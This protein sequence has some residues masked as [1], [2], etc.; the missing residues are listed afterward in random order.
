MGRPDSRKWIVFLPG[1]AID[2]VSADDKDLLALLPKG[3]RT[4][5]FLVINKARDAITRQRRLED[6]LSVLK[7]MIP[8]H[9]DI[10]LIGYSEGAYI[11][12]SIAL[13]CRRVRGLVLLA[14]GTRGWIEDELNRMSPGEAV[15]TIPEILKILSRKTPD[16]L[17][18][19]H[20][21]DTWYSYAADTTLNALKRLNIPV[22]S[23]AG[24]RDELVDVPTLLQDLH[25]L[26]RS[27]RKRLQLKVLKGFNH[28]FNHRWDIVGRSTQRFVGQILER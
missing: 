3:K 15:R 2:M 12:P 22:L 6:T 16:R 21:H 18:R 25:V 24:S 7:Q 9:H 23:V 8:R 13:R 1:S 19:G 20:R 28:D 5:H 14:G 26:K 27:K 4:A 10:I 17:W 11:A